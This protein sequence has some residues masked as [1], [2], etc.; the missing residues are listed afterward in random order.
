MNDFIH[1]YI[2]TLPCVTDFY[3]LPS[4]SLTSPCTAR[5]SHSFTTVQPVLEKAHLFTV[6]LQW[7]MSRWY[8]RHEMV[9]ALT[10][11]MSDEGDLRRDDGLRD[12]GGLRYDSGLRDGNGLL[13]TSCNIIMVLNKC[14][15]FGLPQT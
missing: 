6:Q 1:M 12:N 14:T 13:A 7:C 15:L 11:M 3:S 10:G 2:L 5:P 9:M 4:L 8:G